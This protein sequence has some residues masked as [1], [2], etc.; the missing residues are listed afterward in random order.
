MIADTKPPLSPIQMCPKGYVLH[1]DVVNGRILLVR[2][3]VH[4]KIQHI[5]G[6]YLYTK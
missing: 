1:H 2:E 6:I 3:D 5:G 4:K